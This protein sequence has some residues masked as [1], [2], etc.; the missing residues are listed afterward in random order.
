MKTEK[1]AL[2]TGA[3]RGIGLEITRLAQVGFQ[4][5][6]TARARQRGEEVCRKLH[7]WTQRRIPATRC[8]GRKQYRS[9]RE[10]VGR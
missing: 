3:K 5:F 1:I 10:G 8:G 4:V 2:V 9:T 7:R 6:I